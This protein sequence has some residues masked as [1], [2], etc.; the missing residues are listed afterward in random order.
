MNSNENIVVLSARLK[1][2][3]G[4]EINKDPSSKFDKN[5]IQIKSFWY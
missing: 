4:T 5:V 1:P 3:I 2:K